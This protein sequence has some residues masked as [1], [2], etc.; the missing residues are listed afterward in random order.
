MFRRSIFFALLI[1]ACGTVQAGE[2]AGELAGLTGPSMFKEVGAFVARWL[3][4]FQY[5]SI[6]ILAGALMG[7]IKNSHNMGELSQRFADVLLVF[8]FAMASIPLLN[9]TLDVT[10]SL[11]DTLGTHP[12]SMVTRLYEYNQEFGE[13]IAVGVEVSESMSNLEMGVME[14]IRMP[15]ETAQRAIE[16][17]LAG[18]EGELPD[19]EEV[20][21]PEME[22][23]DKA[24]WYEGAAHWLGLTNAP[25]ISS[26]GRSLKTVGGIVKGVGEKT[27]AAL[28]YLTNFL[29]R[30]ATQIVLVIVM[31]ILNTAILASCLV[32]LLM[33]G[34]RYLLM[35]LGVLLLPIAISA[36]ATQTFRQQGFSYVMGIVSLCLWPVGWALGH[37]GTLALFSML[38]GRMQAIGEAVTGDGGAL[39][40]T[41]LTGAHA[42]AAAIGLFV[43]QFGLFGLVKVGIFAGGIIVLFLVIWIQIV[44]FLAP[45]AVGRF[46]KSGGMFF[47]EMGQGASQMTARVIGSALTMGAFSGMLGGMGGGGGMLGGMGGST[48]T[49]AAP[50]AGASQGAV[51][52]GDPTGIGA[53]GQSEG[54]SGGS[55]PTGGSSGG[56]APAGG[57]ASGG[58][59]GGGGAPAGGTQT[60]GPGRPKAGGGPRFSLGKA[61]GATLRNAAR[62]DGSPT[63]AAHILDAS[64][65]ENREYG[66]QEAMIEMSNSMKENS[67]MMREMLRS[68]KPP[69]G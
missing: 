25:I 31:A 52:G 22:P 21:M 62:Y 20:G 17:V 59:G 35:Y 2:I 50:G 4:T 44:T 54:I 51:G 61:V 10:D 33:D 23:E 18:E 38:A 36:M 58:G 65:D 28:L 16:G 29:S 43:M 8:A 26:L 69:K 66:S 47:S 41:A 53:T 32:V 1:L 60:G 6:P 64:W 49:G 5:L 48:G 63:S 12:Y 46:V 42:G 39:S 30:L 9:T 3:P 27:S 67:A 68:Q 56:G 7:A 11:V 57:G 15:D 34:M 55:A 24:A 40:D 14:E 19:G 45:F 13:A 37:L